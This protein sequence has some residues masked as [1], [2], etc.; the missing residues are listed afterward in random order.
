MRRLLRTGLRALGLLALVAALG[1]GAALFL[2]R[3]PY[4]GW[5]G[6]EVVV[7]LPSG[8]SARSILARLERAGVIR[9]RHLAG[10]A[11]RALFEGKTLKAGEYRFT[12]PVSTEEVL[13]DLV[14]GNVVT[15]RLTIPEGWT[16]EEVFALLERERLAPA[17]P[18]R[19]LFLKP[20]LFPEVP[21]D[22][23]TLEG[24]LGPETHLFTRSQRPREIVATLVKAWA[25]SLPEGFAERAAALGR[26]PLEAVTLASLVEKETGVARER[27]LVSAVY[28]NRLRVGMPLQCDPTV[29]YALKR[30]G[31]WTGALTRDGLAVDD[32]Y[33]TYARGGLPPG[34]IASPG[35]AALEAAVAPAGVPSLYFVAVG[36][37]SGEHRFAV[38][39]PEHLEN[40]ALY[41]RAR[42][43][44]ETV[45]GATR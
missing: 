9:N 29:V 38:T 33:N 30:R 13:R 36:D 23:P 17:E 14:E 37:G 8:A 45:S 22:A 32:P 34:P 44:R 16:A 18:L 11:Y 19:E 6:G 3:S 31:L 15:H 41:R 24:F 40:V 42:T 4:Q 35:A 21:P 20:S 43:A 12:R 28:H 10:A 2:V 5:T 1:A 7:E 39:Y 26:T 27:P 25:R